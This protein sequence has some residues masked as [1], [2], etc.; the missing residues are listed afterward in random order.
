[1]P[2][3]LCLIHGAHPSPL[4][5]GDNH[6]QFISA[7]RFFF[8]HVPGYFY[9]QVT[10]AVILRCPSVLQTEPILKWGFLPS[11]SVPK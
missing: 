1:M 11:I 2:L 5:L 6:G 8:V 4:A 9:A 7:A 3:F 10:S